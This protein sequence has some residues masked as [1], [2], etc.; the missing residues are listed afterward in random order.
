MT[1]AIIVTVDS[2][3]SRAS[4]QETLLTLAVPQE[5]APMIAKFLGMIHQHVAVAFAEVEEGA[6]K[7]TDEKETKPF[8]KFAAE[9][10]RIG[11]F[12]NQKVLEA[13]GT[14]EEYLVWLRSQP[15]AASHLG[16]CEGD[17]VAAHVRRIANGAGTGI[18]PTFSAIPLCSKH[19]ALQHSAGESAIA[20]R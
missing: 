14:D 10:Y 15:C 19:H 1:D 18:K 20:P 17:V 3:R 4:T 11:W 12:F 8:G 13:I 6:P 2:V 5:H 16:D 9:L 7:K